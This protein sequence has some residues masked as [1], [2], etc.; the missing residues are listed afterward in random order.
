M[1]NA[2]G[3]QTDGRI[4][5]DGRTVDP[6]WDTSWQAAAVRTDD[7]WYND[8]ERFSEAEKFYRGAVETIE[9]SRS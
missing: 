5:N 7:G 1:T 4:V 9:R 3:I 8:W 6:T 2:L